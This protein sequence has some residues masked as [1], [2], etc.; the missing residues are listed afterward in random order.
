MCDAALAAGA[1]ILSSHAH[2]A[3]PHG[4]SSVVIIEDSNLCIHTWPK[5]GYAVA[6]FFTCGDTVD[7]WAA[8]EHLRK[9]LKAARHNVAELKRGNS[10]QINKPEMFNQRFSSLLEMRDKSQVLCEYMPE[11]NSSYQMIT[12]GEPIVV[13]QSEFQ[14]ILIAKH[15]WWG[16]MLWIDDIPNCAVRDEFT[17]H[18]MLV[19][20]PMMIQAAPKRVL[21][22]GGGDGCSAREVL[23]HKGLEKVVMV[24]IDGDVVSLCKKHLPS[25]NNGAFDDPR[26]ELIIGDGIEYVAKAADGSFDVIIVDSTD[27]IPDT[28]GEVLFTEKFYKNCNRILSAN[29]VLST[30]QLMPMKITQDIYRRSLQNLQSAFDQD[31]TFIYLV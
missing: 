26:L 5:F 29:G 27:A 3:E 23:R 28:V 1:T 7:P 20:V 22:I 24:D 21:I 30:Q 19:Q 17:Y 11:L 6:D 9:Y 18:E 2:R 25:M 10:E 31:R 13:K 15:K 4:V 12:E 14:K 8:F 16:D